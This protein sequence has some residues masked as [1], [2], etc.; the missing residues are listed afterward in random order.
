[1]RSRCCEYPPSGILRGVAPVPLRF[2][3]GA[4]PG[5]HLGARDPEG[6]DALELIVRDGANLIRLPR[7]RHED[8]AGAAP[9]RGPLPETLQEVQSY[10][11]WALRAGR[12]AGAPVHV[13]VNLGRLSAQDGSAAGRRWL[14]YVVE[15]FRAHPALGV[16]KVLDEPNNPYTPDEAER[17]LRRELRR[18]YRR[19]RGLDAE[20]PTWVTQA[21]QPARRV[22][23]AFFRAYRGAADI[24]AVDL[25]PISDP[26]GR[27]SGLRNKQPS[28]VGD[29]A[30]RLAAA[31][32]Q[33]TADGRPGWVWMV[34]QGASWSGVV[35]RDARRR[36]TGP[37]LL[38]PAGYMVRYM[39]YQ[40]IIH[41]AQGLLYFGH[42]T[43]L[44]PEVRPHG[45]D[46]GY[47]RHAVAP[48]LR[49]LADPALA[50]ALAVRQDTIAQ[51]RAS[52][53]RDVPRLDT[54]LLRAPGGG[55]LL[56][57]SRSERRAGEPAEAEVALPLDAVAPGV[58]A[59]ASAAVL[60][61]GRRVRLRG[62]ELR[63]RFAP[64]E[65]H[66]YRP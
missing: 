19:V 35:P 28:A 66:V 13:A 49:E 10:L 63:D 25:Y 53:E 44:H 23:T 31:T 3:R 22:T 32:R 42:N 24:H 38:Q 33:A 51:R 12:A 46:W 65:V 62:G 60:F 16:W 11:D 59:A 36:P 26:V 50:G 56:L 6:G 64:H 17:R 8:L 15:R 18:G 58:R 34:L 48:V 29:Y 4:S 27:H 9:G 43:G 21:P 57:A 52:P 37:C 5:P 55:A 1:M 41:G 40:S 39:T 54:R 2:A 47:W 30:A 7:I 20:H 45:W 14:E 61:E